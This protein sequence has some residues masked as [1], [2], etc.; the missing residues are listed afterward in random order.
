MNSRVNTTN[1]HSSTLCYRPSTDSLALVA[2]LHP[3]F[4]FEFFLG[5]LRGFL[6]HLL[7]D[8]LGGAVHEVLGL[9][10]AEGREGT[11]LLDDLD[12][13]LARGGEDDVELILLLLRLRRRGGGA[14]RSGN[15]DR[16]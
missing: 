5:L 2:D 13:L 1:G 8:R 3:F 15:R 16:S 14:R 9:L 7:Q 6:R 12:L 11:H 4:G 10:E